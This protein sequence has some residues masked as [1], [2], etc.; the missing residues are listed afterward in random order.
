[1][2]VVAYLPPD[3]QA[4]NQYR[5]ANVHSATQ[6]WAPRPEPCSVP[7]RAISGF[8]PR[9]GFVLSW[10]PFQRAYAGAVDRR[11]GEVQGIHAA[12]LGQERFMEPRHKPASAHSARRR[13][14]VM[15]EPKPSSCGR[16]S[17]AMPA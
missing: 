6:R 2:N 10:G 1:M 12:K 8:T 17:Q 16:C 7:R 15:P 11:P 14:Q 13:L 5:W 3:A 4:R 9:S